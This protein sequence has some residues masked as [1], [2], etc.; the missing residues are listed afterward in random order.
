MSIEK[1]IL[2]LI[3]FNGWTVSR[4]HFL[5]ETGIRHQLNAWRSDENPG[6][7]YQGNGPTHTA[8]ADSVYEAAVEL[9]VMVGI[10]ME[11][12]D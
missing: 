9:A 4:L 5:S 2:W 6:G 7:I 10:E 11:G 1:H 8:T 3:D 12:E